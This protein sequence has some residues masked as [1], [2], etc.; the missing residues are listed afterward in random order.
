MTKK[1]L[2]FEDL[3]KNSDIL[4]T[5]DGDVIHWFDMDDNDIQEKRITLY[6]GKTELERISIDRKIEAVPSEPITYHILL[7][8]T[9]YK[10]RPYNIK[11]SK[12][13]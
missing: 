3:Y 5:E 2:T 10:V 12:P 8:S 11:L 6:H 7:N 9:L 13:L 1:Q 4:L